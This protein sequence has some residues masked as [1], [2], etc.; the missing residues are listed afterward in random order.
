M[1]R[2]SSGSD[3]KK[4][5]RCF[6]CALAVERPSSTTKLLSYRA[7]STSLEK[8]AELLPPP[9]EAASTNAAS[10][11][12]RPGWSTCALRA[13]SRRGAAQQARDEARASDSSSEELKRC[14]AVPA[15]PFC[16]RLT[17]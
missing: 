2:L 14:T 5:A 9:E 8:C 1:T 6:K 12:G 15:A 7:A 17:F 4:V 13:R 10:L 3:F 11:G 16:P